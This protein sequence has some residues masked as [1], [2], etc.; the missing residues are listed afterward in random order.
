MIAIINL[1]QTII[2]IT[3]FND[4]ESFRGLLGHCTCMRWRKCSDISDVYFV[5]LPRYES[6]MTSYVFV[7]PRDSGRQAGYFTSDFGE[8]AVQYTSHLCTQCV[9]FHVVLKNGHTLPWADL[10]TWIRHRNLVFCDPSV[11]SLDV[12]ILDCAMSCS[13]CSNT[14]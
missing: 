11:S 12:A 8:I 3:P 13:D 2:N 10:A 9:A 1:F 14:Y 5:F 4:S 7:F 6:C